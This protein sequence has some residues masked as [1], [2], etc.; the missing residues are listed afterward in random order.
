MKKAYVL[1][2]PGFELI[3]AMTPVDVLTRSGV[4]VNLVSILKDLEVKSSQGVIVKADKILT[5]ID[6]LDGDMLILP[7]G[8]PG[9]VNLSNDNN[10]I[11]VIKK[12]VENDKF[13]GAICG[14][15]TILAKSHILEGY[16]VTA[17]SSTRAEMDKYMY[18][19]TDVCQD[20][21]LITG[22]GAGKSL[23]FAFTLAKNLVTEEK[24]EEVKKG[25]EIA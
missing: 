2:A 5:E 24:I 22:I 20:K 10:V 9:Y 21:N 14:A 12:Y 17:H 15:P 23:E 7:G 11:D 19:G 18:L 25:M 1:L 8:Y 6:T 16:K 3:E 13:I 4:Q